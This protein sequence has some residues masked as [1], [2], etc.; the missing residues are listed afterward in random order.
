MHCGEK[1]IHR[2]CYTADDNLLIQEFEFRCLNIY[3]I[4]LFIHSVSKANHVG[5]LLSVCFTAHCLC[6]RH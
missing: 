2:Q 4:Y 5:T 6:I 1:K 3:F